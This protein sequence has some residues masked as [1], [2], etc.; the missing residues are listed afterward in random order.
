M[1]NNLN[2]KY[3]YALQVPHDA[4]DPNERPQYYFSNNIFALLGN[5]LWHRLWHLKRGDGWQ[6]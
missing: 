2:R 5:I 3:Y 1:K 6:D 4:N